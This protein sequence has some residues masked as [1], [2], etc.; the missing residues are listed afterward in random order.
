MLHL[1]HHKVSNLR[2]FMMTNNRT[3]GIENYLHQGYLNQ[4]QGKLDE[5]QEDFNKIIEINPNLVMGYCSRGCLYLQQEDWGP[6]PC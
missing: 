3:S 1:G 5:A 2:R 6:G 4:S